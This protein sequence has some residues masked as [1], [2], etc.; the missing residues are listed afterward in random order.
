MN[1]SGYVLLKG[2][3]NLLLAFVLYSPCSHVFSCFSLDNLSAN[4]DHR[5]EAEK[6]WVQR[7]FQ[8]V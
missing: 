5:M 1:R 3:S 4:K 7:Q 2:V 8:T 6:F